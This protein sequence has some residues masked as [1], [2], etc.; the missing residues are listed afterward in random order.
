MYVF[1]GTDGSYKNDLHRTD[2]SAVTSE[3]NGRP[4][5]RFDGS[6]DAMDLSVPV[7]SLPC[8][9][10]VVFKP[11]IEGVVGGL[12][13]QY[14]PGGAAR[15]G[16]SVNQEDNGNTVAGRFN[17]FN[18]TSSSGAGSGGSHDDFSI[19]NTG[20]IFSSTM[21]TGSE[22]YKTYKDGVLTDSSTITGIY[23]G[24]TAIGYFPGLSCPYDGDIAAFIV[25]N[26]T[27]SD[28]ERQR[29]ERW[30]ATRYGITLA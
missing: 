20:I 2:L 19:T 12:F 7:L 17:P 4:V 22:S 23:N 26:R 3:L 24:N 9:L 29:V 13:A 16:L 5:L 1:G 10:F 30:L 25:F 11:T 8:S 18:I 21:A 27:L 6:N 28:A 14:A 15:M